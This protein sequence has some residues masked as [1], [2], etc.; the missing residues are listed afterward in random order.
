VTAPRLSVVVPTL[1][2]REMTAACVDALLAAR[3]PEGAGLEV[4]VVDDG[5]R[6]GTAAELAT[7]A[8]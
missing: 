6:D 3:L 7:C 2:T 5:S 1:D 4:V 8:S